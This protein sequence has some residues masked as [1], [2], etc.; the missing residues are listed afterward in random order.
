MAVP[1][2]KLKYYSDERSISTGTTNLTVRKTGLR[3]VTSALIS[4]YDTS[5]DITCRI[6]AK[7]NSVRTVQAGKTLAINDE[8]IISNIYLSNASGSAVNFGVFMTG[9]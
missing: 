6:N 9:G 2:N 1:T 3:E 7:N 5:N 8:G 4:N